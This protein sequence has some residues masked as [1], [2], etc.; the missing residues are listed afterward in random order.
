MEQLADVHS[1]IGSLIAFRK[2]VEN[3]NLNQYLTV[4]KSPLCVSV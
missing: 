1:Q 3:V 2:S 4:H